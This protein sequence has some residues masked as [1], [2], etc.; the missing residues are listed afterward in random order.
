MGLRQ[1]RSVI[2]CA[3]ALTGATATGANE[4]DSAE[5]RRHFL[6]SADVVAS[7]Q[8]TSGITHAWRLTL[9]DGEHTHDALFQSI[10]VTNRQAGRG[11]GPLIDSYRHSIAAYRLAELVGLADMMPVT[12]ERTWRGTPGAMVWWIDDVIYDEQTRLAE[13][14]WPADLDAWGA[15][16]DRMWIFAELVHDTDRHGGNLLYTRDWKLHMIDF[17]RAF[18]AGHELMKPYRLRRIDPMLLARF[19]A[20][21]VRTVA[22]ATE[23]YLSREQITTVLRRRDILVEHFCGLIPEVAGP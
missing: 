2:L 19:E 18:Q 14:R 11:G 6:A 20:L 1:Y 23:G 12:V 21:S 9:S 15:Q 16:V 17:T 13:R 7:E 10:D 3:I 5:Q 8:L 4:L 22:E